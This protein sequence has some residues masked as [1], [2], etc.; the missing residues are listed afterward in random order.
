[1][2]NKP[3]EKIYLQMDDEGSLHFATWC[4]DRIYDTDIEYTRMQTTE[5]RAAY[6]ELVEA[7][8]LHLD[9]DYWA[10]GYGAALNAFLKALLKVE[11]ISK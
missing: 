4:Q 11:E 9:T 1:M 10:S 3:P 8:N 7:A 6:K 2:T 5:Q